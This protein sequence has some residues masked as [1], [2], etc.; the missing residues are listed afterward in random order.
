LLA[1]QRILGDEFGLGPPQIGQ[2][3]EEEQHGGGTGSS[4]EK[5]LEGVRDVASG[6]GEALAELRRSAPAR[7]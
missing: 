1:Q 4:Q 3:A 6:I 7:S 5:P 2:C